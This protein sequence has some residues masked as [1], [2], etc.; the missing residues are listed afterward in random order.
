LGEGVV[1]LVG[2]VEVVEVLLE[3][4]LMGAFMGVVEDSQLSEQAVPEQ[5]D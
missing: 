5:L 4:V 2:V 1:D 3:V